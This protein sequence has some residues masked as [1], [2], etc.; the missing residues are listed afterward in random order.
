MEETRQKLK[1]QVGHLQEDGDVSKEEMVENIEDAMKS[2]HAVS[3]YN[4]DAAMTEK[5]DMQL[6]ESVPVADDVAADSFET[7]AE[8][9]QQAG[10]NEVNHHTKEFEEYESLKYLET[11][12]ADDVEV[13]TITEVKLQ[14]TKP[15]K[16]YASNSI[17]FTSKPAYPSQTQLNLLQTPTTSTGSSS[18]GQEKGPTSTVTTETDAL[19]QQK[20]GRSLALKMPLG[21]KK[22][23][24]G[25]APATKTKP[26]AAASTLTIEEML[27]KFL[28]ED[29][30]GCLSKKTVM[31]SKVTA[32]LE[33]SLAWAGV[34]FLNC[35]N[36]PSCCSYSLSV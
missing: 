30:I 7:T 32:Y 10:L 29:R 6:Q 24:S 21:T 35:L 27:E 16:S 22:K 18:L 33:S 14:R 17:A 28:S 11:R 2:L 31:S 3:E 15:A 9:K 5:L 25:T 8:T 34:T 12:A 26:S 23:R 36:F 13:K 1:A 4:Q 20:A 19:G